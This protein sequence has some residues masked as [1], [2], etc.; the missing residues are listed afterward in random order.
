MMLLAFYL[1]GFGMMSA[2]NYS[3]KSVQTYTKIE[4]MGPIITR[5]QNCGRK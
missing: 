1:G 4:K 3:V 2:A 5:R